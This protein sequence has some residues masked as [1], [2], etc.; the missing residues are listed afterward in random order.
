[1]SSFWHLCSLCKPQKKS[2]MPVPATQ[3]RLIHKNVPYIA[4][5]LWISF[6]ANNFSADF[7]SAYTSLFCTSFTDI[8]IGK[9][10]TSIRFSP[11]HF[12]DYML[13]GLWRQESNLLTIYPRHGILSRYSMVQGYPVLFPLHNHC[14]FV[15][16]SF[17]NSCHWHVL[18]MCWYS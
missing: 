5:R 15:F 7:Y 4:S 8:L 3:P 9:T 1:M 13:N 2:R 17:S 14:L 11:E 18:S 6:M 12:K 16:N 10:K